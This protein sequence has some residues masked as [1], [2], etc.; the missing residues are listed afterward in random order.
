MRGDVLFSVRVRDVTV[1][2]QNKSLNL[3]TTERWTKV[4]FCENLNGLVLNKE[5][6]G[7]EKGVGGGTVRMASSSSC[8]VGSPSSLTQR[9]RPPPSLSPS[10]I[11]YAVL[12]A[13][14]SGLYVAWHML[15]QSS[16]DSNIRVDIYDEVGIGGGASGVSGGLLHPYSPKAKLLWRAA[17]CWTESL[18]PLSAAVASAAP[19]SD[20]PMPIVRRRGIFRPAL[21]MK[22]LTLLKDNA[23]SCL[24]SCRIETLDKDASQ[25]LIPCISPPL[26]ASFC[27]PEAVNI[28]PQRYLQELCASGSGVRELHLHKGSVHKLLD[29]EGEYQAVIVCLGAKAD[30]LPELCGRLPLRLCRGVVAHLQLPDDI[31]EA[32]PSL[33]PLILSDAWLAVQRPRCLYM[34]STSEWKSRNSSPNV[35]AD[36]AREAL[37]ELLPTRAGLRA[38]PPLTPHGSLCLLGCVHDIVDENRS[39]NHWLFGGLGSRGLLYHGWLGKLMAQAV[40]S[41]NEELFPHESTSW[42]K[43]NYN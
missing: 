12:G 1:A 17:D 2:S 21:S 15:K 22:N 23:Q 5:N 37:K 10:C 29:L 3:Q 20:G 33:G 42:K 8:S 35:F 27:M 30:M 43:M 24:A 31:G 39:S 19:N 18:N 26:D 32:Y 7:S 34:G 6:K 25:S 28:H 38:M 36:E 41:C 40:L 11:R 4:K 9:H 13:G 16:K 14:F